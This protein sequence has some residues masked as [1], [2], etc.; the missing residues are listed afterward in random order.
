MKVLYTILI[1]VILAPLTTSASCDELKCPICC[2]ANSAGDYCTEDALMC[3]LESKTNFSKIVY[4]AAIIIGF[5]VGVPVIMFLFE[6]L[7]IH[8]IS[9]LGMSICE[10]LSNCIC[11]YKYLK[12]RTRHSRLGPSP[13]LTPVPKKRVKSSAGIQID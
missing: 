8:R 3:Q 12:P 4:V 11:F 10:V 13:T 2:I 7:I 9:C 5:L 1:V 6:C